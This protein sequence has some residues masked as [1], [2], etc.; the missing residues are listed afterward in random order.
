MNQVKWGLI[1][2]GDIAQRC[3]G[4]ALAS[5]SICKLVA[6]SRRDSSALQHCVE[7]FGAE[8]GYES[9]QDLLADKSIQAVYLGRVTFTANRP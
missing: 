3:V 9:W 1:G 2:C 4:P 7:R 8:R 5:L 6:V